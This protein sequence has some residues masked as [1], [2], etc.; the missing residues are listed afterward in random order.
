MNIPSLQR[1]LGGVL[2]IMV[3][4][5]AIGADGE[6]TVDATLDKFVTAIGGKAA[7]EKVATRTI[8]A[9]LEIMGSSTEWRSEA[10]APDRMS[11]RFEIPGIGVIVD[12]YD[13]KV[14]WAKDSSG[15]R[16]KEG[17]ELAKLKREADIHREIKL[18]TLFPGLKAKG[19]EK[20]EGEEMVILE[21]KPSSAS[22]E[23]F[24]FGVNSG[25]LVRQ[26]SRMESPAGKIGI[27]VLLRDYREVDGIKYPFARHYR[28]NIN[29]QEFEMVIKVKEIKHN[30]KMD[31]A[32]FAKP[33]I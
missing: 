9:D 19:T 27:D 8:K 3:A 7:M 13:G 17:E 18:K 15:V 30:E 21:S 2:S 24:F 5:A 29:G 1:I 22:Q 31:D 11:S 16:V 26:E 25:L 6:P 23:R 14:A 20:V 33:S 10:K 28:L 12:G 4:T 32:K